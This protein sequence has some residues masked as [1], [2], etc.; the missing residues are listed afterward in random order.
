MEAIV[1]VGHGSKN[2]KR[3]KQFISFIN[4]SKQAIDYSVQEIGWLEFSEPKI[5]GAIEKCIKKGATAII[6]VPVFLLSGVHVKKDIPS[7]IIAAQKQYPFLTIKV[8][9]PLGVDSIM[10]ELLRGKFLEKNLAT[11]NR[12]AIVLV[13]HGSRNRRALKEFESLIDLFREQANDQ[14]DVY[15]AYLKTN[16]PSLNEQLLH[17]IGTHKEVYVI[18]H[19][20]FEGLVSKIEEIINDVLSEF[21]DKKIILCE[22]VGF[23]DN[24]KELIAKRINEAK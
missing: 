19:F 10:V 12:K 22:P 11:S 8:A 24:L 6:V 20:L 7:Q 9:N 21:V 17:L 2:V 4:Y 14:Q 23:D 5:K 3:N 16:E 15:S 18:P 13:S 1:Y